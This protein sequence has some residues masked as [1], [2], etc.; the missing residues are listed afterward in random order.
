MEN[1]LALWSVGATR[2]AAPRQGPRLPEAADAAARRHPHPLA[3]HWRD[4]LACIALVAWVFLLYRDSFAVYFLND[5][6]T[7]LRHSSAGPLRTLSAVMQEYSWRPLAQLWFG[8]NYAAWG[9][10]PFGYHLSILAWHALAACTLYAIGTHVAGRPVGAVA[11][12]A[13]AAHPLHVESISWTSACAH[14]LCNTFCLLAILAFLRWRAGRGPVFL[15]FL[16]HALALLTLES[17][18]ILPLLVAAT[19]LLIPGKAVGSRR[20]LYAGL[21]TVSAGLFLLR[22]A[23]GP[24]TM[25]V[26]VVGFDP[27]LGASVSQLV[28]WV[29]TRVGA[30]G[31]PLLTLPA[32]AAW[33]A[34]PFIFLLAVIAVYLWRRRQPLMVWGLVWVGI[35]FAPFSLML[36]GPLPRDM[37]LP[38]AG[39]GLLLA[40]VALAIHRSVSRWDPRVATAGVSIAL[41]VWLGYM[42]RRIDNTQVDFVKRGD[43]V[44][45][46]LLDLLHQLPDPAPGSTVAFYGTAKMREQGVFVFGLADAVHLLYG[47]ESLKLVYL[48]A[49]QTA[50]EGIVFSYR[51]GR[52]R[53]HGSARK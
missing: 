19:D 41:A 40:G 49:D 31:A 35:A 8:L 44:R 20:H 47:D 28:G 14:V 5:D 48:A 9:L 25:S 4:V 26:G 32:G 23:F 53:M 33:I 38:V 3:K 34:W 10:N 22:R 17:A 1:E 36:F 12:A 18:V 39:F 6:F 11:A 51:D 45:T 24:A 27:R 29:L 42:S 46:V 52:L 16:A 2:A 30:A 37:Y 13:F 21:I 50:D 7:W 43:Q 15:V